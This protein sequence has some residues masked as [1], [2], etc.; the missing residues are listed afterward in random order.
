MKNTNETI[1]N[2]AKAFVR[3][4]NTLGL[5]GRK[6]DVAAVE[7]FVG[8][9]CALWEAGQHKDAE[10]LENTVYFFVAPRGYRA[11][12]HLASDQEG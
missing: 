10:M 2:L 5:T 6:R 1:K 3:R 9:C 7:F 12:T 11:V 4:S 8:C